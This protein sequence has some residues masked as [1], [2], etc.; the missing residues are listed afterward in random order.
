MRTRSI[1]CAY[2]LGGCLTSEIRLAVHLRAP[3]AT[4]GAR[5]PR[6]RADNQIGL[7]RGALLNR[8]DVLGP[9]SKDCKTARIGR[10]RDFVTPT[11]PD[12]PAPPAWAGRREDE[13]AARQEIAKCFDGGVDVAAG[14]PRVQVSTPIFSFIQISD[15]QIRQAEAKLGDPRQSKGL[16]HLIDSF[17]HD[18]EQELF[19]DIMLE[20]VVETINYTVRRRVHAADPMAMGL[21]HFAE[22]R[23]GTVDQVAVAPPPPAEFHPPLFAIHTGDAIDAGLA[24]ELETFHTLMDGLQ[25]CVDDDK[26]P[27]ACERIPWLSVIGNHDVLTFGNLIPGEKVSTTTLISGAHDDLLR[28]SA[29]PIIE[30][31]AEANWIA[32]PEIERVDCAGCADELIARSTVGLEFIRPFVDAHRH[33]SADRIGD[34][35]TRLHGFDLVGTASAQCGASD[36]PDAFRGYYCFDVD[37]GAGY[38]LRVIVLDTT[39]FGS[40][41]VG[42]RRGGEDGFAGDEQIR[43]FARAI[44]GAKS[45]VAVYGHHPLKTVRV[46]G[47][48]DRL[49]AIL[50]RASARPGFLG[51]FNG[52]TH[53]N[54]IGAVTCDDDETLRA[55]KRDGDVRRVCASTPPPGFWEVQTASIIGFPQEARYITLRKVSPTIGF[56][57]V[58]PFGHGF[59]LDDSTQFRKLLRRAEAG[60]KRDWCRRYRGPFASTA[61]C[62]AGEPVRHDGEHGAARLFV[63]LPR[64]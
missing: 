3:A 5:G 2:L 31:V 22:Q 52:H 64:I 9:R 28:H 41:R 51:Y 13:H 1:L 46:D 16:D 47:G 49:R 63:R 30:K 37:L 7:P 60:A 19:L 18:F 55:A 8:Y 56:L 40:Q 24:S 4:P 50:L 20:A 11:P 27:V 42:H 25:I 6:D 53:A 45:L 10:F 26:S 39:D 59:V 21:S 23:I 38:A 32:E 43:W 62:V 35:E 36:K 61:P 57:E 33:E 12:A 17:E 14:D 44:A 29:W 48:R 15:V 34:V 54:G 58:I